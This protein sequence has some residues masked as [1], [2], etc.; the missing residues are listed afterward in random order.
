M[1]RSQDCN[2]LRTASHNVSFFTMTLMNDGKPASPELLP[3]YKNC[4][5]ITVLLDVW[6]DTAPLLHGK[7]RQGTILSS[8]V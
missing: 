3:D 8:A 4:D 1:L 5:S 2:D 6:T 7:A